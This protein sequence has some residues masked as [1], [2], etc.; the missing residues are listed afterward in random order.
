MNRLSPGI[1]ASVYQMIQILSNHQAS[2]QTLLLSYP[3]IDGVKTEDVFDTALSCKWIKIVDDQIQVSHKAASFAHNFDLQAK[4]TMLSEYI[5]NVKPSWASLMMKGRN[6]CALFVPVD[7]LACFR[8]AELMFNPP[9]DDVVEW[10][11]AVAGFLREE[12]QS[13]LIR[14]GRMGEK[15]SLKYEFNRTKTVPKW[16]AV[17]SNLLG[18]DLLSRVSE[19]DCASLCIEV[20]SSEEAIEYATAHIT[21]NEWDMALSSDYYI[22]HFWLLSNTSRLAVISIDMV[23]PHIPEDKGIGQWENVEI[24]FNVFADHFFDPQHN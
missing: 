22:F 1:L 9:S 6:E 24:P 11:D 3:Y 21:R 14:I 19:K 12:R 15:L 17:E 2:K 7:V 18:Y 13:R 20:K 16:Q 10:W 5:F 4:R 8:E 23:S